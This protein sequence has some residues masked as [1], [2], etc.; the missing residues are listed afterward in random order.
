MSDDFTD[1]DAFAETQG[2]WWAGIAFASLVTF[3]IAGGLLLSGTYVLNELGVVAIPYWM[4]TVAAAILTVILV[5]VAVKRGN[6][7]EPR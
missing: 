2:V 1:D 3:A 6:K 7:Y 4:P 5:S